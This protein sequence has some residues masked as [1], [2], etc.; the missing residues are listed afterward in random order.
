M[1]KFSTVLALMLSCSV[2]I[3]VCLT[4]AE[5]PSISVNQLL[6]ENK[7]GSEHSSSIAKNN[8]CKRTGKFYTVGQTICHPNGYEFIPVGGNYPLYKHREFSAH[9]NEF[10]NDW[11]LNSVRFYTVIRGFIPDFHNW[12]GYEPGQSKRSYFNTT[13]QYHQA[14]NTV[15][16]ITRQ[17]IV[18][19]LSPASW[20]CT[21]INVTDE[22]YFL[23]DGRPV[24]YNE[25]YQLPWSLA[26]TNKRTFSSQ[27]EVL[28]E[29]WKFMARRFKDNPYVWFNLINE[30]GN[31]IGLMQDKDGKPLK[32]LPD[33]WL[34][35]HSKL[36]KIIR[37]QGAKN[38]IVVDEGNACAQGPAYTWNPVTKLEP[39][40]ST[41]L[42]Y[43][44]QLVKNGRGTWENIIFAIHGYG[45]WGGTQSGLVLSEFVEAVHDRGVPLLIGETGSPDEGHSKAGI[46]LTR[47]FN[48]SIAMTRKKNVGVFVF[49]LSNKNNHYYVT[50]S[51]AFWDRSL[52]LT[53]TGKAL[54]KLAK[55][56]KYQVKNVGF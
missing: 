28:E 7:L 26:Y 30:P 1:R 43:G 34:R 35:S 31:A 13:N 33:F 18:V 53:E 44:S 8:T 5:S 11:K 47:A 4:G 46:K 23:S 22:P 16:R 40:W 27:Q 17:G 55:D 29:Y 32:Q 25:G 39:Q 2:F 14:L 49:E 19:M 6:L 37:Q 41:I 24:G 56:G 38:P 15:D 9:I 3:F 48:N 10:K 45:T 54:W 12:T 50:N 36:I 42:T 21:G 51:G 52:G 20:T